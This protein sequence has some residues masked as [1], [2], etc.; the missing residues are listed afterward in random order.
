MGAALHTFSANIYNCETLSWKPQGCLHQQTSDSIKNI[1]IWAAIWRLWIRNVY[2]VHQTSGA[3]ENQLRTAT[4]TPVT[5]VCTTYL[6][7]F[8]RTWEQFY[9]GNFL[10]RSVRQIQFWLKS[11]K[12]KTLHKNLRELV[13]R[14]ILRWLQKK[15][16]KENSLQRFHPVIADTQ[17]VSSL[18]VWR[19]PEFMFKACTLNH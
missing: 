9:A 17:H 5:S 16:P 7:P 4:A 18:N 14:S 6:P 11:Y 15:F 1:Q 19:Q 2:V 3:F 13:S 12:I 8:G 10:L